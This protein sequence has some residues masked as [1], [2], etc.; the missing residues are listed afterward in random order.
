MNAKGILD[1]LMRQASGRST[2]T[3]GDTVERLLQ[4][5]SSKL[6]GR[7][8]QRGGMDMGQLGRGAL[9]L[10]VGSK[11]GRRLG[12]K[13]MKY[14]AVAGVGML[15]WNAWQRYQAGAGTGAAASAEAEGERVERLQGD[16]GERRSLEILQAM[17]MAARADGHIDEAEGTQ[18]KEQVGALGADSELQNWMERQLQAPL[19][20]GALAEQADS[21]QAAREM[22]VATLAV[23]DEQNPMER[24]WLEQLRG[25]L[26][27]DPELTAE[28][29]REVA[30]NQ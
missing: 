14:G 8:G 10:L 13:A 22:Y 9:A 4:G 18:L 24:A 23:V 29:E 7:S 21:P 5:L 19:D 3:S 30:A 2:G 28:L 15:A 27:L 20:A 26:G 17:I 25:A 1:Q 12:G 11:R 6:G 16:A